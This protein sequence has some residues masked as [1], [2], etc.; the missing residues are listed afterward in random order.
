MQPADA[1]GLPAVPPTNI[2]A[3]WFKKASFDHAAHQALTCASCHANAATSTS[4]ADLLLPGIDTCRQCHNSAK[5]SAGAACSTC[6]VY[7][8]WSKEKGVNGKYMIK[9]MTELLLPRHAPSL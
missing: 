1:S 5:T 3:R 8:D 7:H 2:S 6:H 9:Q 4:S